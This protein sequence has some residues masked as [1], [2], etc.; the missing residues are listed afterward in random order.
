MT[1]PNWNEPLVA[2]HPDGRRVDVEVKIGPNSDGDYFITPLLDGGHSVFRADGTHWNNDTPWRIE[3]RTKAPAY[4]EGMTP[5]RWDRAENILRGT[6]LGRELLA[7]LKPV[8]DVRDGLKAAII[9]ARPDFLGA[10][11]FTNSYKVA[12]EGFLTRLIDELPNHGLT[13]T[14][15]TP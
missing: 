11:D 6:P 4:P 1:N 13:I 3:N 10:S 2:V 8:D 9:A 15:A 7:E 14:E 12:A 5:E